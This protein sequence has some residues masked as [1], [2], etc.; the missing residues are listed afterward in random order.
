[1]RPFF[2][3]C[4]VQFDLA[5]ILFSVLSLSLVKF[6]CV[7]YVMLN[8]VYQH[9]PISFPLTLICSKFG[10][11]TITEVVCILRSTAMPYMLDYRVEIA[12]YALFRVSIVILNFMH[13]IYVRGCVSGYWW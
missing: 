6:F 13:I 8:K 7:C 11:I 1:M 3:K 5:Y 4:P 10:N 2:L 12:Q 9:G